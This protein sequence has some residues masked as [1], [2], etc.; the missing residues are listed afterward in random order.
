MIN[1]CFV[2][3]LYSRYDP[4][5]FIRQGKS[6]VEAGYNVTYIV[7]DNKKDEVKDGIRIISTG[8]V[9]K[10]RINRFLY[11]KRI[12]KCFIDSIDA[13]I[14]QISDPELICL[15]SYLKKKKKK[16]VLNLREYYPDLIRGK[17]YIPY[18]FRRLGSF[19]Y[20]QLMKRYLPKY[21]HVFCPSLWILK[22]L[23][24]EFEVNKSSLLANYPIVNADY[25]LTS[26]DY[27]GRYNT[28]CYEG[29][30]YK[31]SRQEKVFDA[32]SN[33]PNIKYYIAG[34]IE[35]KYEDIYNHPYWSKVEFKNGFTLN[36][37]PGIFAKS[38]ISNTLRD[39]EKQDGSSG[40][41]KIFESM[42]AAIPILFSDVP[43]YRAIVDKYQCGLCV[44][45]NDSVQIAEAINYL[46]QHKGEAYEM[47]QRGR[48]AAIAEYN[49]Q[50]QAVKYISIISKL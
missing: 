44:N 17:E 29:T 38:T 31:I 47:G 15:V 27:M 42:E 39:F 16:V 18:I 43:L 49:W 46:I 12:I 20:T 23:Q 13:D 7:C 34:V 3:G 26:A 11:T 8:F 6:L 2:S 5:I 35:E 25:V 9:P 41:L 10:N 1:Y 40:V 21:D 37:L 33:I 19:F 22:L 48:Q 36:E 30:V 50:S 45:P 4:L 24:E 32:L 28:L 14:Y